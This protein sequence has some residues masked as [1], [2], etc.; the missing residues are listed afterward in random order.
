MRSIVTASKQFGN[1]RAAINRKRGKLIMRGLAC[2]RPW[3]AQ[4]LEEMGFR[5][6][7]FRTFQVRSNQSWHDFVLAERAKT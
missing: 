6:I 4:R 2:E 3:L 1:L 7:E 5:N